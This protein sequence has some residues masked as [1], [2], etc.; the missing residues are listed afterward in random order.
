MTDIFNTDNCDTGYNYAGE[1]LATVD[2]DG[3]TF[4]LSLEHDSDHGAPWDEECGHGPVSDWTTRD[5]LPGELVLNDDGRSKR[6]Y[7]FAEACRIARRDGWGYMPHRIDIAPDDETRAPYTSCGG[8]ANAIDKRTGETVF[9]AYDANNF[10]RAIESV[11]AQHRATYPSA[12][13]Y[14]AA[15]AR[16]DYE[17]LRDW[18]D[19]EWSYVG[20][21]VTVERNGIELASASLWGI[22]S[23]AGDYF[24]TVGNELASEALEQARDAIAA[25]VEG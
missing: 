4:T 14:A 1:T 16:A 6:Y 11:Y 5:K 10:N 19:N 20:A 17:H 23:T 8:T 9:T 12:R 25:L 15:A 24:C 22:E 7:D 21:I 2:H 13:A 18:C 3:F